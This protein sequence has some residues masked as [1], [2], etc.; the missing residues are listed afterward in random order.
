VQRVG[1]YSRLSGGWIED[2]EMSLLSEE[3]LEAVEGRGIGMK[4]INRE[5]NMR[6][7]KAFGSL[8]ML[9]RLWSRAQLPERIQ[10]V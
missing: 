10:V 4:L 8:R 7:M 1:G 6:R 3:E 2:G 9:R 5:I